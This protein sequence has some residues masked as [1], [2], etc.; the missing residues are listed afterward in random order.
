MK[1]VVCKKCGYTYDHDIYDGVCPV[2][3]VRGDNSVYCR[4]MAT[5]YGPPPT[6]ADLPDESRKGDVGRIVGILVTYSHK[7]TGQVFC[8][9]EGLNS[10]GRDVSC[11]ISVPEDSQ[12]MRR[13]MLIRYMR[14]I[15]K[16]ALKKEL[17]DNDVYVNESQFEEGELHN[18]DVIRIG[19][20]RF[21]FIVI[22]QDLFFQKEICPK[23]DDE[24]NICSYPK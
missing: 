21:L 6:L 1:N 23:D 4:P 2:C 18:Y 22:P 10:V 19:T 9:Y 11:D 12:M 16:F 20:T 24:Q 3:G 8:V 17:P 7:P 15:G 14:G 5:I 13:H